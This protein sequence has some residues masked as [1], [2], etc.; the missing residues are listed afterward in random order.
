MAAKLVKFV[1]VVPTAIVPVLS[2]P[3][4]NLPNVVVNANANLI[5]V[6]SR[7]VVPVKVNVSVKKVAAR[8]SPAVSLQ[9]VVISASAN[10]IAVMSRPVVNLLNVVVNANA[11]LIAANDK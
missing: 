6:K 2:R 9:S 1:N 10:L 4:V 8:T 3:V 11:N 7:P 5:A